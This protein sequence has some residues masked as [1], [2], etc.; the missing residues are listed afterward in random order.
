MSKSIGGNSVSC[1]QKTEVEELAG[2]AARRI[3][4]AKNRARGLSWSVSRKEG[5]TAVA[6]DELKADI[7][8]ALA[9]G[10][11]PKQAIHDVI[12]KEMEK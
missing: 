2:M 11:T 7:S 9:Q 6:S 1:I 8:A 10:V 5:I 3:A 4:V 12:A